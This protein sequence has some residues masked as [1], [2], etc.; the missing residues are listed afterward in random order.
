MLHEKSSSFSLKH[1]KLHQFSLQAT[2]IL[3]SVAEV[4]H[5]DFPL[6]HRKTGLKSQDLIKLIIFTVSSKTFLSKLDIFLTVGT[7]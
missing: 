5:V 2:T 3:W 7:C 4:L 1:K 6:S